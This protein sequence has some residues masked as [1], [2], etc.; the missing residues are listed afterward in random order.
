MSLKD[1]ACEYIEAQD[2]SD[3]NLYLDN[4]KAGEEAVKTF[5]ER[6]EVVQDHSKSY[7]KHKD[8]NDLLLYKNAYM[9]ELKE[10]R[11]KKFNQ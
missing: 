3:I 2:F 5:K 11:S 8:L 4:D 10:A 1:K 9:Q 7:L 6:F